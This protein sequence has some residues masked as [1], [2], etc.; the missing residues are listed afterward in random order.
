VLATVSDAVLVALITAMGLIGVALIEN[1]RRARQESKAA[2]TDASTARQEASKAVE[3]I[4]R[5]NGHGNVVEMLE[6][7]LRGQTGQDG[8]LA[9]L[10]GWHVDKEERLRDIV[11][12]LGRLEEG[13]RYSHRKLEHLGDGVLEVRDGMVQLERRQS[14]LEA[15]L[16]DAELTVLQRAALLRKL[17]LERLAELEP[18]TDD[19]PTEEG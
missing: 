15:P 3:A 7:L 17:G 11:V 5:P 16:T 9:R 2:S 8:R 13:A 19:R 10:E 6:Q 18:G 4:G 14:A 1:S 12:R